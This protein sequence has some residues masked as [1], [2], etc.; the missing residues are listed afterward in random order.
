MKK[1]FSLIIMLILLVGCANNNENKTSS[2]KTNTTIYPSTEP[3]KQ[4]RKYNFEFFLNDKKLLSFGTVSGP[5]SNGI[6]HSNIYLNNAFGITNSQKF[7]IVI[8]LDEG[9]NK[10]LTSVEIANGFITDT[11]N[12]LGYKDIFFEAKEYYSA[13]YNNDNIVFSVDVSNID[14]EIE[15]LIIMLNFY[16]DKTSQYN[17][18]SGYSYVGIKF[19]E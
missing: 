5:T 2:N 3:I 7:D 1:I 19:T 16:Y 18:M 9:Y 8:Y 4:D 12:E 13:I 6:P 17:Y 14:N 10:N 15:G 11:K